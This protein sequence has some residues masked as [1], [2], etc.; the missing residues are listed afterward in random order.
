M[1]D[2]RIKFSVFKKVYFHIYNKYA[3]ETAVQ[4]PVK[5]L[6]VHKNPFLK[7]CVV[8]IVLPF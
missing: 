5:F 2:L 3:G 7:G 8:N 4:Q 6:D 1:K